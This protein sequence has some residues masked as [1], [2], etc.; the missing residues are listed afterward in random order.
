MSSTRAIL[1]EHYT[2]IDIHNLEE[3]LKTDNSKPMFNDKTVYRIVYIVWSQ[4]C[5]N[6]FIN[7]YVF[8]ITHWNVNLVVGLLVILIFLHW[9]IFLRMNIITFIIRKA[10]LK[11]QISYTVTYSQ[12][13]KITPLLKWWIGPRF[14]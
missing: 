8:K 3:Y 1:T 12:I 4:L 2:V 10:Q 5:L 7:G 9:K 11:N 6:M 14:Q 13:G